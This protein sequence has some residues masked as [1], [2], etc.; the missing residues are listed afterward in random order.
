MHL[1]A[2]LSTNPIE[3]DT[4]LQ[5]D[6]LAPLPY[7]VHPQSLSKFTVLPTVHENRWKNILRFLYSH[8]EKN[9]HQSVSSKHGTVPPPS[10]VYKLETD[11]PVRVHFVRHDG[12][13][14]HHYMLEYVRDALIP[15]RVAKVARPSLHK[16]LQPSNSCLIVNPLHILSKNQGQQYPANTMASYVFT[17]SHGTSPSL[18]K[19]L[20]A[21]PSSTKFHG[22]RSVASVGIWDVECTVLDESNT[23][24]T[25]SNRVLSVS[26]TPFHVITVT[27][28]PMFQKTLEMAIHRQLNSQS[29]LFDEIVDS[30]LSLLRTLDQAS[31]AV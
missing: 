17:T 2:S 15:A 24:D 10:C 8:R 30:L 29:S 16:T 11:I 21:L 13:S 31:M 5:H 25:T 1:Y 7:V 9:Y 20:R 3:C 6:I 14:Y 26:S 22:T 12:H 27:V 18:L 19:D 23:V 4:C 28:N